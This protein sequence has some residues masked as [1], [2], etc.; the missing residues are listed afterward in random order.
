MVGG[1]DHKSN[2]YVLAGGLEHDFVH[3][4]GMI[5]PIDE[6]IFLEG[7]KPPTRYTYSYNFCILYIYIYIYVYILCFIEIQMGY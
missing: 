2:N 4:L 6:L 7:L 3:I 5:I 1:L